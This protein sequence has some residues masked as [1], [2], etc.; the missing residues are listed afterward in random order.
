MDNVSVFRAL[1]KFDTRYFH[2]TLLTIVFYSD[3]HSFMLI[4]CHVKWRFLQYN[5][6][7]SFFSILRC[8]YSF[9]LDATKFKG[10][11]YHLIQILKENFEGIKYQFFFVYL[12]KIWCRRQ[13]YWSWK[14]FPQLCVIQ[15]L[16]LSTNNW[17]ST[18]WFRTEMRFFE[19][20][21]FKFNKYKLNVKLAKTK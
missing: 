14:K 11:P 12:N 1:K 6:C 5:L 19:D 9:F 15:K 2:N 21:I 16:K 18:V 3:F 20:K 10:K 4:L 13:K 8:S 7:G 17:G